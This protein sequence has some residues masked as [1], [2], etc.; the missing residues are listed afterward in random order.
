V[1]NSTYLLTVVALFNNDCLLA[2]LSAS[3]HNDN[4]AFLHTIAISTVSGL[5]G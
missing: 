2:G 5:V 3:E 4:S 1:F